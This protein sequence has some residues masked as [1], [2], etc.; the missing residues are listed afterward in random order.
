MSSASTVLER[1][2]RWT[3]AEDPSSALPSF[4]RVFAAIWMVYDA[5]DLGWGMTER[6]RIW[7]PHPR[8]H[9]LVAL[10]AVLL[11]SGAM[12]VLGRK[13]WPFGILA[14][15][16][17]ALEA[18]R[19]FLL[20]D[21]LFVSVV[22]LLLAHSEGGPFER[23]YRPRWVRDVL[24]LQLAWIYLCTGLLKLNPDWLSGGHLF[25]RT[26]YLWTGHGWPYPALLERAFSSLPFDAWM[27]R[28]GAAFEIS[29][30]VVL[31]ARRPYWLAA[32]LV[33]G[34]HAIGTLVTNVW[35]FSASMIAG[36]LLLMPRPRPA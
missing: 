23:R 19:F 15:V 28:V 29:L 2:E 20:N 11:V 21:F 32:V 12:L 36:V 24:L 8:D 3:E 6:S 17:R 13:V 35:F 31:L 25:V 18:F 1:I 14:A 7:F 27:S 4:R 10:Q 33:V 26:Q 9:D 30:G 16:A 22:C 5:I 34:I